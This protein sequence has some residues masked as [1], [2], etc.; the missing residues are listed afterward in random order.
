MPPAPK[1]QQARCFGGPQRCIWLVV[2][3]D[4][5]PQNT[6][7]S[8]WRENQIGGSGN[9]TSTSGLGQLFSGSTST[10]FAAAVRS[11]GFMKMIFVAGSS[12]SIRFSAGFF[13]YPFAFQSW[14]MISGVG[15]AI[16]NRHVSSGTDDCAVPSRVTVC[17]LLPPAHN[18]ASVNSYPVGIPSGFTQWMI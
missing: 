17:R 4:I 7:G 6:D 11:R 1:Y 16:P 18:G 10:V 8:R 5:L 9:S 14:Q 3:F 13:L 15:A 2:Y 12:T